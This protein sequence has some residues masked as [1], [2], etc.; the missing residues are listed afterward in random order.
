MWEGHS[1]EDV[2]TPDGFK[3]D[4]ELVHRFYNE[5]RRRL[6][7]GVEPNA[8]HLALARLEREFPGEVTVVTQNIDD[9][10]ER[11]GSK[12]LIHMH[13]ELLKSR[14][15]LCG[16]LHECRED[17]CIMTLCDGCGTIGRVRPHVVWF[18]EIPLHM[19]EIAGLVSRADCFVSVGTSGVVYPAAGYVMLARAV[20]ARTVEI[21]LEESEGTSMFEE[22]RR[23][24]AGELVPQFVDEILAVTRE[25]G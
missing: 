23:G 25:G 7:D 10:H 13:G 6:L 3:R 20:K 18:G 1:I 24:K 14:C 15:T 2:A 19:D 22:H 4:P 16:H 17:T 12:R 21:N 11:A 5:R 9:L 8:A